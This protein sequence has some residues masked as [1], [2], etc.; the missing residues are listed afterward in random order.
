MNLK[1]NNKEKGIQLTTLGEEC[2][3]K[4]EALKATIEKKIADKLGEKQVSFLIEILKSD[5]GL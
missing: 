1:N 4:N 2:Y 5:W 3:E